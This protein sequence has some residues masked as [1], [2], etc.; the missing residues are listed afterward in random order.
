MR[1][2]HSSEKAKR[3]GFIVIYLAESTTGHATRI[4]VPA[5][6]TPAADATMASIL[7]DD[8]PV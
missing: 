5:C 3:E 8:L 4:E 7:A 1:V 6:F 2:Y